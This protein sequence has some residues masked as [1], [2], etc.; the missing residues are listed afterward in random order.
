[1]RCAGR[2]GRTLSSLFLNPRVVEATI[3]YLEVKDARQLLP[4]LQELSLAL[5]QALGRRLHA[6]S[7]VQKPEVGDGLYR[8]QVGDLLRLGRVGTERNHECPD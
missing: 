7:D 5:L 1:M 8:G 6:A 4:H 3:E 2:L